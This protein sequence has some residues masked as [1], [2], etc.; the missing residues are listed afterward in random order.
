MIPVMILLPLLIGVVTGI[1]AGILLKKCRTKRA[2]LTVLCG[3]ILLTAALGFACNTYLM[4]SPVLNFMLMGMAFS[5]AFSNM[6]LEER[7][8]RIVKDFSPLLGV[9]MIVVILN[10][11]APLD[12]H[13]ILG[14]G[15]YT[16]IYIAVRAAGKY[17]GARL[18]AKATGCR[19]PYRNTLVSPSLRTQACRWYSQRSRFP[20]WPDPRRNARPLYRARLRRRL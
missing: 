13:A 4:P 11:G 2:T 20:C 3:M 1:P 9:S 19:T 8:E 17:F 18:G 12:Y 16:C 6:A 14:A 5:A 7:L 15:L 10:L